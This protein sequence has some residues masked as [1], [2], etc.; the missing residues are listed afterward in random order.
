[1]RQLEPGRGAGHVD[2]RSLTPGTTFI[3]HLQLTSFLF[4]LLGVGFLIVGEFFFGQPHVPPLSG[5]AV[6]VFTFSAASAVGYDLPSL[7]DSCKNAV[8]SIL[9]CHEFRVRARFRLL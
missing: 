1:M 4:S 9:E 5:L 7:R 8:R 2:R 3:A 6:Y